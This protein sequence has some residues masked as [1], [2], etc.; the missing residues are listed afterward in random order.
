MTVFFKKKNRGG[1]FLTEVIVT[2]TILSV[3]VGGLVWTLHQMRLFNLY[4]LKQQH[5]TAAAQAQLESLTATGR[6]IP[7]ETVKRLWPTVAVSVERRAG[8][9]AWAGL[10]KITV[11][12]QNKRKNKTIT[13][14]LSRYVIPDG[15]E[16]P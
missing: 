5:C 9:G 14:S 2:M 12:A 13:V 6:A 16:H 3:L 4:Q 15:E 10:E 7:D 1:W 8:E 11:T